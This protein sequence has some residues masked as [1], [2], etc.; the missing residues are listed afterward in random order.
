[1]THNYTVHGM[2]CNGC[3]SHVEKILNEVEKVLPMQKLIWQK[4]RP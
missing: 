1:M 4:L 2:T 3:R